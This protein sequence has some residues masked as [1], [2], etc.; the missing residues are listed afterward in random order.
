MQL[1]CSSS[2][3]REHQDW[4]YVI[5]MTKLDL[6]QI[7]RETRKSAYNGHSIKK[8]EQWKSD[9][10]QLDDREDKRSLKDC[11][12]ILE[13]VIQLKKSKKK[14]PLNKFK[15][16]FLFIMFVFLLVSISANINYNVGGSNRLIVGPDVS[17]FLG[18]VRNIDDIDGISRFLE[19]NINN[20]SN[21]IAAFTA[22]N[23]LNRSIIIGITGGNFSVASP[24]LVDDQPFIFSDSDND[25]AFGVGSANGFVWRNDLLNAEQY[26]NTTN[27]LM[28]LFSNG[29]LSITQ[30]LTVKEDTSLKG[31]LFLE[32]TVQIQPGQT[33]LL[34]RV[35]ATGLIGTVGPSIVL[36]N[37]LNES[38]P[39]SGVNYVWSLGFNNN[40]TVDLHDSLDPVDQSIAVSHYY[41]DV[42]GHIWRLNPNNN[43]SFFQWESG[44][45]NALFT[46]NG[47]GAVSIPGVLTVGSCIG[48]GGSNSSAWNRSGTN[49][50]LANIGDRVGIGTTTPG[51]LLEVSGGN[52]EIDAN[53]TIGSIDGFTVGGSPGFID[54]GIKKGGAE[55]RFAGMRIEEVSEVGGLFGTI[56]FFTDS[57]GTDF[58]TERMTITG[59]GNIGIGTST[60]AQKLDIQGSVIINSSVP[61]GTVLEV[62]GDLLD[63]GRILHAYSNNSDG[64]PRNIV[65]IHND[66]PASSST[67]TLRIQQDSSS[68]ILNL[69]SGATEVFT[70]LSTGNVGIGTINP[71][72]KLQVQGNV[73]VNGTGGNIDLSSLD[74]SIEITRLAGSP[75]IDWKNDSGE[76]FDFRIHQSGINS[77]NFQSSSEIS[78]LFLDG[79][80]NVGIGLS[81]PGSK[82]VVDGDVDLNEALFVTNSG[83]VGIGT[84]GPTSKLEVRGILT[85]STG[86]ARIQLN[87][88][89][90]VGAEWWILPSTGGNQDLFRIYDASLGL[91]RFV[92]NSDGE[93]GIGTVDP[94]SQLQV[95]GNILANS[96]GGEIRLTSSDGSIEIS[97]LAG[98]PF[99][100]FKNV[101][102][103]DFDFRIH[104]SGLNS[105]NFQSSNNPNILFLDGLG[106][107]GIGTET[108]VGR[109]N[110]IGDLNVTG[111]ITAA[112]I[113]DTGTIIAETIFDDTIFAQLSSFVDQIPTGTDPQV[114]TYNTQDAINRINH[115][116]TVNPGEITIT[117]GGTYFVSPQPQVGKDSG[118]TKVDF[119]MFLQVDRNGT[120]VNEPNSNIKLTI[121]DADVTDVIVSAFTIELGAGEKIRMMQRTSNSG[122]GMGLK[123]TNITGAV[124]RT[125]SIIFTM[126]RI[127][128]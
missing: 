38:T 100:D 64:L 123:N 36:T 29:N 77:M 30:N 23:N 91:D 5:K 20:E 104:Q 87:D 114:I 22:T 28:Q 4:R 16:S 43:E 69:F 47:T 25:M 48:C 1:V 68:D 37:I 57:E 67:I 126:Y 95:I 103:E 24:I 105:M 56:R 70:V 61:F 118:G 49:V 31:F 27:L 84:S 111:T 99:I 8:L 9:L 94:T 51:E 18:E 125:P 10:K 3:L 55:N 117:V 14:N 42:K 13:L 44:L 127:G 78:I 65:E 58:S 112:T 7:L 121:K 83:N 98:E 119:D 45:D 46:I 74:G 80:G 110:V 93:V 90:V 41:N 33:T 53:F 72:S 35:D 115:S 15:Q 26:Q 124:P 2:V 128:G 73:F 85:V 92:I 17:T 81:S 88:T 108:P 71:T 107:V 96:S 11:I 62:R 106:N 75:F 122:V 76:D 21:A 12:M 59:L 66:N 113:I 39:D 116:T 32:E 63:A 60:P 19:L 82:F 86:S 52:I 120:F 50:F 89:G 109:L 40:L 101:N 102:A 54:F 6:R 97:R 34:R 79:S